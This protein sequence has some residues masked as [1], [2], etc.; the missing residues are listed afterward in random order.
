MKLGQAD[1]VKVLDFGI[2]ARSESSDSEKEAKLTQK[3]MVLGTPP[4]MSPEQFMGIELD[5]RSDIY[6][7][8]IM[9][10]EMLVGRLPFEATTPWQWATAHMNTQPLA[11][12]ELPAGA[13][14][15]AP[16]RNVVMSALAKEPDSPQARL[17]ANHA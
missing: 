15:P 13:L 17:C 11:M 9:T 14:V 1:F 7:L 5:R 2:A 3:G 12:D 8:G 16:I 6:S 4:Y 10:Y